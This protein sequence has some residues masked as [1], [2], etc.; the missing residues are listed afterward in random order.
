M[1]NKGFALYELLISI[2][3]LSIILISLFSIIYS[4]NSKLSNIYIN[5]EINNKKAIIYKKIASDFA[6]KNVKYKKDAD[7][8]YIFE[9]YD[10][11][12]NK[13]IEKKLY[14]NNNQL[15]YGNENNSSDIIN[16]NSDIITIEKIKLEEK[17][18]NFDNSNFKNIDYY[19]NYLVLS[20]D[21]KY[22]DETSVIKI[23]CVNENSGI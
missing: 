11:D 19:K 2:S 3:F 7:N 17:K 8:S 4:L 9:F 12:I 23:Y 22:N 15:V 5:N 21:F 13:Y 16:L 10:D 18:T 14:I 20:I 1:K 6:L